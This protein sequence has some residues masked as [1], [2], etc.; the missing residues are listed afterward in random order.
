LATITGNT[1]D[2]YGVRAICGKTTDRVRLP[3]LLPEGE[4][5]CGQ[6]RTEEEIAVLVKY[7]AA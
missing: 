7:L 1:L 4:V 5:T 2:G 6:C 3:D